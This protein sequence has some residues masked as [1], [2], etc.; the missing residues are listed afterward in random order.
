MH[1]LS[2]GIL[3]EHVQALAGLRPDQVCRLLNDPLLRRITQESEN[4]ERQDQQGGQGQHGVERQRGRQGN[5]II[6]DEIQYGLLRDLPD[7]SPLHDS[8]RSC[9]MLYRTMVRPAGTSSCDRRSEQPPLRI[10]P[11]EIAAV[12]T[13]DIL[14]G[15]GCTRR[16]ANSPFRMSLLLSWAGFAAR[17][18]EI[19]PR[20]WGCARKDCV[21]RQS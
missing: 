11:D 6:G 8:S 13:S 10:M 20:Q 3:K 5:G 19:T 1:T 21:K 16:S 14:S 4:C 7:R 9:H 2:F 17:A 18:G 15:L 12:C